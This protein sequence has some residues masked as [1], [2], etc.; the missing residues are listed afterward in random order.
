MIGSMVNTDG[1]TVYHCKDLVLL[2]ISDV[3]MSHA[4]CCVI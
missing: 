3:Y 4:V 1:S 2:S